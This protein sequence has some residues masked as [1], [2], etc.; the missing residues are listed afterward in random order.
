MTHNPN[1][2][3]CPAHVSKWKLGKTKY[4]CTCPKEE[5]ESDIANTSYYHIAQGKT[6]AKTISVSEHCNID[7]D[8]EGYP[9]G[10]ETI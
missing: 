5:P 8:G 3:K 9:I 4:S 7:L 2:K 6:V 10:I 1:N